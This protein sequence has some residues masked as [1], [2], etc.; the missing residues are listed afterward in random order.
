MNI[1]LRYG[2]C[3]QELSL[4]EDN[5]VDL[6]ITDP[7]YGVEYSKGFDDSKKHVE[8]SVSS[9]VGEMYRVLKPKHH[10]YIF[11]PTKELDLW[12]GAVRETGFELNNI[13]A[14]K[15][16]TQSVYLRNNFQYNTQLIL[17]CSKGKAKPFNEVDF[18]PTSEAWLKD[19]RNK[20]PKPYTYSYP[21]FL[22]YYSNEKSTA[23]NSNKLNRHPCSK[24][25][26]LIKFLIEVSTNK[27]D[28]VMDMF[29]GGGSTAVACIKS[30]RDFIGFENNERYYNIALDKINHLV[31]EG[32]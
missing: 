18:I 12:I 32:D 28:V 2:D 15:T 31:K 24:N 13:L 10:C 17:Y 23:K 14:T 1:D 27:N 26:D 9:W 25:V 21:S 8:Q 22:P 16:Y 4:V 3:L 20:N 29:V 19:K 11:V 6:I 5:S 7:P 30:E